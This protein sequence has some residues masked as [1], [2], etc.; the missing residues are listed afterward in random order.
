MKFMLTGAERLPGSPIEYENAQ[1]RIL[2]DVRCHV[3]LLVTPWA[4]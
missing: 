3:E 1:M 2:E 4:T